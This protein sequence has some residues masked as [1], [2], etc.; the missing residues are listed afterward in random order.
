M[1][2]RDMK[3]DDDIKGTFLAT[4]EVKESKKSKKKFTAVKLKDSTGEIDTKFWDDLRYDLEGKVF[5]VEVFGKVTTWLN[6]LQIDTISYKEVPM[7]NIP[8]DLVRRA[9]RDAKELSERIKY[10]IGEIKIP[11]LQR[12]VYTIYKARWTEFFKAP[13]AKSMHHAYFS[14]LAEHKVGMLES[15]EFVCSK[16][17]RLNKSYM[18][19]GI[20]MHDFKKMDEMIHE[21]GIVPDYTT[22]GKLYGH[23]SMASLL[24]QK[25][26]I[27]LG[28]S[29]E[30]NDYDQ[31]QHIILS[32]HGKLEWGSPVVPAT[33]EAVAVHYIDNM[34]AKIQAAEDELYTLRADKEWT[35]KVWGL[36]GAQMYRPFER[37][38][39]LKK[40]ESFPPKEDQ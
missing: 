28:I 1:L 37:T 38:E 35:G 4:C 40:A 32:H 5:C 30:T 8:K 7:E 16:R 20:L 18:Y 13:A 21:Y 11:D 29:T 23:I 25:T 39:E 36:D 33:P 19:A 27:E 14:G 9:E 15:A 10:F 22:K 3:K 2:I 31:V 24:F 17:P 6:E 12:L 26:A 34:D